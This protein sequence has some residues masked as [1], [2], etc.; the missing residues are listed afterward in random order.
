MRDTGEERKGKSHSQRKGMLFPS[1]ANAEDAP[2]N[3]LTPVVAF[4][5]ARVGR[6]TPLELG[7]LSLGDGKVL[8]RL[9]FLLELVEA[10]REDGL[11]D[12]DEDNVNNGHFGLVGL[13]K[14]SGWSWR[15]GLMWS[16]R[17]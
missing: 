2:A 11:L 12:L 16:C 3:V 13:Q 4:V 9:A 10:V 14:S 7:S 6:G 5:A 15:N 1:I 17:L 8:E